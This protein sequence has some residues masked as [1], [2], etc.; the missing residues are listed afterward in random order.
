MGFGSVTGSGFLAAFA[1]LL[2]AN[3]FQIGVLASIPFATMPLQVFTVALVIRLKRRKLIALTA[4]TGAQLVW[5][6]IALIPVFMDTPGAGPISVLLGL[7]SLRGILA[8][9][10]N[11]AWNSWMR[12]LVPRQILGSYFARRLAYAQIASMLFGLGAA[13]FVDYWRGGHSDGDEVY[14]YT[15]AILFGAVAL[16]LASPVFRALMPERQ[17]EDPP[18]GHEPL[19]RSLAEPYRDDNFKHFVRFMFLWNLATQLAVPFFTVYMLTVLG[20][21]LTAVMALAV[22]SQAANAMFLRMWGPLSDRVGAKPVLSLAA[23]LYL[24]VILGWTFT[25]MPDRYFLTIPLLVALHILA[26]AASSGMNVASGT[27]AIKLAPEG[28][29]TS[30]LTAQ[31]VAANL[32]AAIG[33]LLGGS[34]IDFF[35]VRTLSLDFTWSDPTG[36]TSLPALN[37][38]G[39]DFI[40]GIAFL[41]G[42][43]TLQLLAFLREEGESNTD[44]VLDA[45]LM[46]M[47]RMAAATSSIPGMG[48]V[49]HLPYDYLRRV[50][51]P[52][53]DV[54][55]GVTAYQVAESVRIATAGA[56]RG[57]RESGR[58]ANRVAATV[59][60]LTRQGESLAEF[61]SMAASGAVMAIIEAG[62]DIG[63]DADSFGEAVAGVIHGAL[64]GTRGADREEAVDAATYGAVQGAI[65]GGASP[66]AAVQ[67][68]VGAATTLDHADDLGALIDIASHAARRAADDAA[69]G[70]EEGRLE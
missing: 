10:Q 64:H 43:L 23:S 37:L 35:R 1:L 42:L 49:T 70:V 41:V 59:R 30:F 63:R 34:M 68:A 54:A 28:K 38:T 60:G 62:R 9:M 4:W 11:S 29:S 66:E 65:R 17:M 5:I 55:L 69:G 48:I 25:T 56:G 16:G 32:G 24:L 52:G 19:V 40:F 39:F 7:I 36:T 44:E 2:G 18:G 27:V 13:L 57:R 14:G 26:G 15:I 51:V 45:L 50:P 33:P 12:E 8:A 3:N 47:Q 67:A 21:T 53:L 22:L 58:V 20:M 61:T 31:S 46:P 6:P